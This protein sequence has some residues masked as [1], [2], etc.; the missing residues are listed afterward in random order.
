MIKN[1]DFKKNNLKKPLSDWLVYI[2]T[3][4]RYS[5]N[6]FDNYKH[7]LS[8]LNEFTGENNISLEEVTTENVRNFFAKKHSQGVGPKGIART[9]SA[10]RSF[11]K[12]WGPKIN[13]MSNPIS[14]I[15]PP[16]ATRPLP[17]SLSVDQIKNLL[18]MN[19]YQANKTSDCIIFR[20][21]AIFELLYSSGLRL[22]ELISIDIKYESNI[23]YK[24]TSWI[25][26]NQSEIIVL[27]KGNKQRKL[28]IGNTA[29]NAIKKWIDLREKFVLK[30]N[31]IND[32]HALFLGIKGRRI[33]PRVIQMQLLKLSKTSNLCMHISPHMIRHSFASHLLQS[34]QNLRAVQELLGHKTISTTQIYTKLDFQ[35]LASV[36]DKTHPR[37]I[38]KK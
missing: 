20:D 16:K 18:D 31:S 13:M 19:E 5:K 8:L 17:K 25:N 21:Q 1:K 36:Y 29:L 10:W 35:H 7:D 33:S 24:S 28:P 14:G 12:W 15:R 30:T 23:N 27:G 38:R 3:N 6:T 4:L 32:R 34:S 11:Y 9:L 37:A 22:S 2:Y 26:L